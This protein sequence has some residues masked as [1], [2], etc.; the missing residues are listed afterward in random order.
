MRQYYYFA[1]EFE[2]QF[3]NEDDTV[4][5]AFSQ[6]YSYTEIVRDVL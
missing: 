1:L 4:L 3:E 5:F 2:V 6:P